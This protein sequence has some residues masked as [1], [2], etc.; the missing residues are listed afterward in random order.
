MTKYDIY[1][2]EKEDENIKLHNVMQI[3]AEV[4]TKNKKM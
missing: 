3:L 1:I 2:H 4:P